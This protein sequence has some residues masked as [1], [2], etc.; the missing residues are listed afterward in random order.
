MEVTE[1]TAWISGVDPLSCEKVLKALEKVLREE[2][3]TAGSAKNIF[4][5]LYKVMTMLRK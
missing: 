1:R 5:G 4:D 2:L 3:N